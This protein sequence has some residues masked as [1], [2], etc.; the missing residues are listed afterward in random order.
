MQSV[1][2]GRGKALAAAIHADTLS[3]ILKS[4]QINPNT[5]NIQVLSWSFMSLCTLHM[6]ILIKVTSIINVF[7]CID[8]ILT[9]LHAC[10]G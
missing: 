10:V 3:V 7:F 4:N 2:D 5:W 1:L 9:F 8:L 6:T